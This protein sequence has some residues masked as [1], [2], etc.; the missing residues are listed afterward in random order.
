MSNQ[1][2]L[3]KNV[4][5]INETV[6]RAGKDINQ[7]VLMFLK[8]QLTHL[9]N[10]KEK[11]ERINRPTNYIMTSADAIAEQESKNKN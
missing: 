11:G 3:L 7:S 2:V 6:K 9:A 5:T 1:V 10:R 4:N 8:D